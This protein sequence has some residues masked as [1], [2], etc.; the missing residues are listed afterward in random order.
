M[1][2]GMKYFSQRNNEIQEKYRMTVAKENFKEYYIFSD[3]I[4]ACY[5]KK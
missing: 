4:T 2:M 1:I 3:K 5:V